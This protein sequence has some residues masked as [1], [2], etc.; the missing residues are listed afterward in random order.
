MA[1]PEV[2]KEAAPAAIPLLR[3]AIGIMDEM[4]A[5][6][7]ATKADARKNHY[8]LLA[9][10]AFLDD[11]KAIAE[12][13]DAR[14]SNNREVA[15]FGRHAWY[16]T[17][18]WRNADDEKRSS[19]VLSELETLAKENPNDDDITSLLV[20]IRE[21]GTV[22]PEQ[23]KRIESIITEHL[24]GPFALKVIDQLKAADKRKTLL[25]K[26][27]TLTCPTLAGKPFTT[28]SLKGKS[29]LVH[30]GMTTCIPW[31]EEQTRLLQIYQT[32]DPRK[33]EFV[34][35][36]CDTKQEDVQ[37]YLDRHTDIPWP[38]LRDKEQPELFAAQYGIEDFPTT[39][40]IGPD[41]IVEQVDV[42]P[43][44]RLIDALTAAPATAPVPATQ[45]H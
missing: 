35:V 44:Q 2:R 31:E 25:G 18:W 40:V 17:Q 20:Q 11:K 43:S 8:H 16:L 37:Q 41:G 27:L 12:L 1:D 32:V 30:F 7:P 45:P 34:T 13:D 29:I 3:Q 28:A 26:P 36:L 14:E 24:R 9:I 4:Y 6:G 5:V 23:T 21:E 33:L 15:R 19:E 38:V 39:L 22:N 10:L 42:T